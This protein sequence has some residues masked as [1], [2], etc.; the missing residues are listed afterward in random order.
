MALTTLNDF[1]IGA[2]NS[3]LGSHLER[4][5]GTRAIPRPAARELPTKLP[6]D[7]RDM[8]YFFVSSC[9][10]KPRLVAENF[11]DSRRVL[12]AVVGV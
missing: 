3:C 5:R 8:S 4:L 2:C 12:V 1:R 10:S 7:F 9:S 11:M 6:N